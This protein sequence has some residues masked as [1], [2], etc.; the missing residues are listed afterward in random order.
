MLVLHHSPDFCALILFYS[1]VSTA[2]AVVSDKV[3]R[4][5]LSRSLYALGGNG[6]VPQTR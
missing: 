2:F 5:E 3:C 1:S 4:G 6:C